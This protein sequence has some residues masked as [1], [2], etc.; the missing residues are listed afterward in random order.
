MCRTLGSSLRGTTDHDCCKPVSL[1]DTRIRKLYYCTLNY[2]RL[3]K[4]K[5]C[6]SCLYTIQSCTAGRITQHV[7]TLA[8]FLGDRIGALMSLWWETSKPRAREVQLTCALS[9][10]QFVTSHK[11]WWG[12]SINKT[13]QKNTTIYIPTAFNLSKTE[14]CLAQNLVKSFEIIMFTI[15]IYA[16]VI[17]LKIKIKKGIHLS[18]L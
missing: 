17:W 12:C 16:Y 4:K 13:Q 6:L 14:D 2:W 1:K 15:N 11:V 5:I 9:V 10:H 8:K 18:F 3:I 7:T